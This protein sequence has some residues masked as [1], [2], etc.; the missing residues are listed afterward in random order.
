[1]LRVTITSI[2]TDTGTLTEYSSLTIYSHALWAVSPNSWRIQ[3]TKLSLC[4]LDPTSHLPQSKGNGVLPPS[5]MML[6][7]SIKSSLN[8]K[9][10]HLQGIRGGVKQ[11][12][13]SAMVLTSMSSR[14]ESQAIKSSKP[15]SISLPS[16]FS[17]PQPFQTIEVHLS[18][19]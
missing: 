13:L 2:L 8:S 18:C 6:M 9:R 15:W 3:T 1:M 11:C 7:Q 17:Q 10:S 12:A 16:P 14:I 5:W 4:N 19:F